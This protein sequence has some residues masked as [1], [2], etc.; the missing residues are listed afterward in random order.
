MDLALH[1]QVVIAAVSVSIA[2][3]LVTLI[4]VVMA[5]AAVMAAMAEA[6]VATRFDGLRC[7]NLRRYDKLNTINGRRNL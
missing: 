6:E 7:D 5:G 1:R 4:A 2:I 3:K